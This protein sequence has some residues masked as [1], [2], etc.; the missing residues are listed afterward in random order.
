MLLFFAV[1]YVEARPCTILQPALDFHIAVT[2]C[3]PFC[4]VA[5][6]GSCF[7]RG[8]EPNWSIERGEAATLEKLPGWLFRDS[9]ARTWWRRIMYALHIS[10]VVDAGHW[11]TSCNSCDTHVLDSPAKYW[12]E[13]YCEF[14]PA[15]RW[16]PWKFLFLHW[17]R[18]L[19]HVFGWKTL[20]VA[21]LRLP[22]LGGPAEPLLASLFG[23]HVVAG[24]YFAFGLADLSR[25]WT[26]RAAIA[27]G[28]TMFSECDVCHFAMA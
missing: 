21:A 12:H 4:S 15:Q 2:R 26:R 25:M 22:H 8:A 19:Q 23:Q 11:S 16:V 10:T 3:V 13:M 28:H 6:L 5:G 20:A 9:A 27:G 7:Q 14:W 18:S 24:R 1:P 17:L